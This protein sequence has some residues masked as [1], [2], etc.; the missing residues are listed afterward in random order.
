MGA[1]V[2]FVDNSSR[3]VG[4]DVMLVSGL[5]MCTLGFIQ[6][7]WYWTFIGVLFFLSGLQMFKDNKT[8]RN[9]GR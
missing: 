1:Q 2:R 6:G 5:G 8:E 7:Y 9:E 3:T 4:D